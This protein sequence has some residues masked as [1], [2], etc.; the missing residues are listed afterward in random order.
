M[1]IKTLAILF[2]IILVANSTVALAEQKFGV[3]IYPGAIF[4]SSA[5]EFVKQMA[6]DA[7][8]Y[9]T[10]DDLAKVIEFYKQQTDLKLID[11]NKEGGMFRKG[12]AVDIT[13]QRPWMDM[14]TGKM[15]NDTLISIVKKE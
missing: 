12:E 9:R 14:N 1:K 7:A 11:T 15:I 13:I 3:N 4:D 2:S 5:T 8:C 10:I 6:S